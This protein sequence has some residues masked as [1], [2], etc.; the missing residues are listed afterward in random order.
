MHRDFEQSVARQVSRLKTG[1]RGMEAESARKR[2][3]WFR[4]HYPERKDGER[5]P[6]EGYELF[7]LEYLGLTEEEVPVVSESDSEIVWLSC[8]RCPTLEAC[9]RLGLDPR[10]VCR[11]MTEKPVQALLSQLD[12]QLRFERSYDEIRPH[13][14]HCR[15]R[16]YRLDFESA[17]RVAIEEARVSGSEGNEDYGAVL[18]LGNEIV[19]RAHDTAVTARDPSLH[20]EVNAIRQAVLDRGEPD[21]CGG[22]LF[23]TCEPCPMC[24]SLAVWANLTTIVFGAS[25]EETARLGKSRILMGCQEIVDRS[26][27]L[28]EI[29]GGVLNREC[30]ALYT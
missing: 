1:D 17:M 30:R 8:N 15:E 5:S 27:A 21:L 28:V 7:L 22:V 25:T 29:V 14:H 3:S 20:A 13:A 18:V 6:R 24:A 4:K 23:S 9:N 2:V 16:I 19:S 11:G 26:P 12:P 10:N